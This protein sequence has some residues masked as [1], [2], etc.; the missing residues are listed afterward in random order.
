MEEYSKGFNTALR[1]LSRR[2]KTESEVRD[3]LRSSCSEELTERI[4]EKLKELGYI[5]DDYYVSC[6]IRDRMKFNPMGRFRIK[7]E[8]D[9]KGVRKD[10]VENNTEYNNIDEVPVIMGLLDRKFKKPDPMDES[11]LRKIAGYLKRR[12]FN[13]D[14]INKVLKRLT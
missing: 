2:L 9:Q 13:L 3:K 1:F 14:S 5:D 10:L 12:G 11:D 4:L 6:Y 8:L 7:K